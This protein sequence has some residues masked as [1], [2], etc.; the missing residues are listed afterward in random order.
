MICILRVQASNHTGVTFV[1]RVHTKTNY[2]YESC[3]ST[4]LNMS[5]CFEI[6]NL[7][8]VCSELSEYILPIVFVPYDVTIPETF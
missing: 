2:R 3:E 7:M 8:N 5:L 6:V 4:K 1:V